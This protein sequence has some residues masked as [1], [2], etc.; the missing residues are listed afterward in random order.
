MAKNVPPW[1]SKFWFTANVKGVDGGWDSKE[2]VNKKEE[3]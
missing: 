3:I 2:S 1:P